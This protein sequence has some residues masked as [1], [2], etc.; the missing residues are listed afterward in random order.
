MKTKKEEKKNK[1]IGS[2]WVLN[3]YVKWQKELIDV[4]TKLKSFKW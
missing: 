4:K 3:V 2:I 1:S